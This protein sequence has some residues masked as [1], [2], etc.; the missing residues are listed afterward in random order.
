[1][2]FALSNLKKDGFMVRKLISE[3]NPFANL[4]QTQQQQINKWYEKQ[5][6]IQVST[7]LKGSKSGE[8]IAQKIQQGL[9]KAL[10]I[11]QSTEGLQHD[12][13][14]EFTLKN[15]NIMAELKDTRDL[16][17]S[18]Q[19]KIATL[20]KNTLEHLN[21]I[22]SL[23]NDKNDLKTEL[24]SVKQRL[25]HV[26]LLLEKQGMSFHK[27]HY[28]GRIFVHALRSSFN[29]WQQTPSGEHFKHHDFYKLFPRVLYSSLLKEIETLIGEQDYGYIEQSLTDFV[30]KQKGAPVQH[31]PDEDPIYDSRV[32][33][34]KQHEL[35][36]K[37][38]AQHQR[39]KNFTQYLEQKLAKTGFTSTHSNLLMTLISFAVDKKVPNNTLAH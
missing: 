16:F 39:R 25:N 31:W 15:A 34:Q 6:F 35:F 23:E 30:F 18:A 19:A 13:S 11:A 36:S 37:L 29:D 38:Q 24:S 9:K 12:A 20:E 27:S 7:L 4:S 1:M 32:I 28:V 17:T 21:K 10:L 33:N 22:Q 5:I 2:V 14:Q 26:L 3:D 8:L